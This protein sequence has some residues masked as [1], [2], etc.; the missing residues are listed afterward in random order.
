MLKKIILRLPFIFYFIPYV[1]LSLATDYLFDSIV[2]IFLFLLLTVII[3][4]YAKMT[5]QIS[6]LV[7]GNLINILLSCAL[8]LFKSPLVSLYHSSSPFVAAVPL[9]ALFLITQLTG[10]FWGYILQKEASFNGQN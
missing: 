10:I 4:F 2:G 7:F 8:I 9:I 3:G 1:H 5:Q 6:L